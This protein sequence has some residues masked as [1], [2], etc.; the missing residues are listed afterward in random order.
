MDKEGTHVHQKQGSKNENI[1]AMK[2]P[3]TSKAFSKVKL[4]VFIEYFDPQFN[5]IDNKII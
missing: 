4:K 2:H 3:T 1:G 5:F